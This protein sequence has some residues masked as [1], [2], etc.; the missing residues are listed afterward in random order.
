MNFNGRPWMTP[1]ER[2]QSREMMVRYRE[3]RALRDKWFW[4]SL[5]RE[6]NQPMTCQGD[7]LREIERNDTKSRTCRKCSLVLPDYDKLERHRDSAKCKRRIAEQNGNLFIPEGKIPKFCTVCKSY[8]QTQSWAR[9]LKSLTHLSKIELQILFCTVCKKDFSKKSR[10][11]R[12]YANHL[13]NKIHLRK[14]RLIK[15]I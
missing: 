2:E 12:A 14:T 11:K 4:E 6:Y 7:I 3:N 9:H 10:P 5:S 8:V 1:R 15:N 13:K